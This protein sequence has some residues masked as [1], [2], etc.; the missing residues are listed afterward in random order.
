VA[1]IELGDLKI[2]HLCIA[3]ADSLPSAAFRVFVG[4]HSLEEIAVTKIRGSIQADTILPGH[5]IS[6]R[7]ACAAPVSHADGCVPA[8]VQIS[9]C[10]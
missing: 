1:K 9:K 2:I 5:I 8:K 4:E 10:R 6:F 3:I 7:A